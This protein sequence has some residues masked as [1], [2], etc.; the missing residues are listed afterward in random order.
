VVNIQPKEAKATVEKYCYTSEIYDDSGT[1]NKQ[2][3][4]FTT[5]H[6]TYKVIPPI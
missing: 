6:P 3:P 2:F 1:H 5:N 4:H